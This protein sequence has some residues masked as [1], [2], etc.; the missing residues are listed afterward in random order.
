VHAHG[1]RV[2]VLAITSNATSLYPGAALIRVRVRAA[3]VV[4]DR[5]RSIDK[6]PLRARVGSLNQTELREVEAAVLVTLGFS[7]P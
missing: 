4:G 7:A 1:A 6:V 2:V 5:L 3:R